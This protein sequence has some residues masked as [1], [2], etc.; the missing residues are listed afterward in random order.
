[1]KT[2]KKSTN[3]ALTKVFYLLIKFK[4]QVARK[5][6]KAFLEVG[7]SRIYNGHRRKLYRM[8]KN[9]GCTCYIQETWTTPILVIRL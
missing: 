5:R 4:M 3:D 9:D 2:E 1:M 7:K 8:L 6:R